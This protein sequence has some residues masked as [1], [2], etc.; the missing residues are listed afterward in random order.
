MLSL[1]GSMWHS[2]VELGAFRTVPPAIGKIADHMPVA[3]IEP[4][5][6]AATT[7]PLAAD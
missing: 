5:A 6:I 7:R 4:E 1:D 3:R 2:V